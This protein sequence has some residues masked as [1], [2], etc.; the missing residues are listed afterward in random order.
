MAFVMM[1]AVSASSQPAA[2]RT[3]LPVGERAGRDVGCWLLVSQPLGVVSQPTLY[4][5]LVTHETRAAANAAKEPHGI[6]VEALERIWVFTIADAGWRPAEGTHVAEIGPLQVRSGQHY[7]ALYAEGV[8]N[9]GDVTPVH[10]HPGP[11]AWYTIAGEMC[12]ETPAGKTLAR[13]GDTTIIPA[14]NPIT[15]IAV[16]STQRRSVW[17]VLHP[18][19]QPW[20]APARDWTPKG[21]CKH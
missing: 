16:G 11:E 3:C 17:L 15:L 4:W 13:A 5:H 9:I 2:R 14:D 8:S 6:V 7:T 18:S 12:I 20:T 10:R 21:L 1:N 19:E